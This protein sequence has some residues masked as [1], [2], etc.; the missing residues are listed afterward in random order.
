[1]E[2]QKRIAAETEDGRFASIPLNSPHPF[3][4]LTAG[5]CVTM[6]ISE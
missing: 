2:Q 1:M 5:G 4:Q 6:P 3:Q